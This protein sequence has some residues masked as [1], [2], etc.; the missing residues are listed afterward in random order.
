MENNVIIEE[1]TK[2]LEKLCT[3]NYD[4]RDSFHSV[5]KKYFKQLNEINDLKRKISKDVI[6]VIILKTYGE[7]RKLCFEKAI[8]EC[9]T[10]E[11]AELIKNSLN[12]N[13]AKNEEIEIEKIDFKPLY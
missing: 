2:E 5:R 12:C 11:D 9:F 10:I 7:S 8:C 4:L 1:L 6:F 3:E 13:I